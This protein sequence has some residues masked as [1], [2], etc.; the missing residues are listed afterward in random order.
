[1][2]IYIMTTTL[3]PTQ[4]IR[5]LTTGNVVVTVTDNSALDCVDITFGLSGV[6]TTTI[7]IGPTTKLRFLGVDGLTVSTTNNSLLDC[8]DI[9]I[10]GTLSGEDTSFH[11]CWFG[12]SSDIEVYEARFN[13]PSNTMTVYWEDTNTTD[14]INSGDWVRHNILTQ[15]VIY[16]AT[17]TP[18]D[19]TDL[20]WLY[21]SGP[22]VGK[23]PP[24]DDYTKLSILDIHFCR[25]SG[26]IPSFNNCVSLTQFIAWGDYFSGTLPP[27]N[28]CPLTILDLQSNELIGT[29]PSFNSGVVCTT[30]TEIYLTTNYFTGTLPS[31][32]NC[33]A[34]S[35]FYCWGNQL[36]GTLPSF[37]D[38]L[39]LF[40]FECSYNQFSGTV[41]SFNNLP[42]LNWV[43]I[44]DNEFTGTLP[45]FSNC[46]ALGQL[47]FA[48]N[49]ITG[50]ENTENFGSLD[51]LH[52]LSGEFNLLT[53]AVPNF[54]Y[55][56]NLNSVDLGDNGF[57]SYSL[58][59]LASSPIQRVS[60]MNN[61]LSQQAVDNVLADMVA[62]HYNS[63]HPYR[64]SYYRKFYVKLEGGTN[65]TPSAAGLVNKAWLNARYVVTTTN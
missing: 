30:L 51:N 20:Y 50:F 10:E 65:A 35:K 39:S 13:T 43:V 42:L 59:S 2:D 47:D 11:Y 16:A 62:N 48:N 27:F 55:C 49:H 15:N 8:I 9:T 63:N 56:S 5:F 18:S 37:S 24:F 26:T 22:W 3:G 29:I 23:L 53:G 19:K 38:C 34:L 14:I 33:A 25:F 32:S 31:F 4:K 17:L 57:T 6:N 46:P 36:T 61:A 52:W 21:L 54:R 7:T 28:N 58:G 1:M 40:E 41:P 45:S 60:F 64:P 12:S 44:S